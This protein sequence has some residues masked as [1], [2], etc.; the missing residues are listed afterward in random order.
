MAAEKLEDL[1]LEKLL[2]REKASTFILIF[3]PLFIGA[4]MIIV[5]FTEPKMIGVF[6]PLLF[7]IFPIVIGRK[8]IKEEKKKR[9]TGI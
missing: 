2:K 3:Y 8:K 9:A 7:L 5:L 1:T 4:C 6:I